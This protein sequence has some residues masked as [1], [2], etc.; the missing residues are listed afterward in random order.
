MR[1][2]QQVN[3]NKKILGN[4]ITSLSEKVVTSLSLVIGPPV[5]V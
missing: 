5:K 1:K 2:Q 3:E 4:T